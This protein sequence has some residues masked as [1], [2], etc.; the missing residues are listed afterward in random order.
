MILVLVTRKKRVYFTVCLGR[1]TLDL[2]T[3]C[4]SIFCRIQYWN[5]GMWFTRSRHRLKICCFLFSYL[6]RYICYSSDS[7]RCWWCQ[8][9]KQCQSGVQHPPGTAIFLSGSRNRLAIHS[10]LP[11]AMTE[12]WCRD[13]D[14]FHLHLNN[15]TG[16]WYMACYKATFSKWKLESYL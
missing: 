14:T 7:H 3:S 6:L 9:W 15:G 4:C 11:F 5:S 10:V 13:Q 8:L 16:L 12:M 1:I 2:S